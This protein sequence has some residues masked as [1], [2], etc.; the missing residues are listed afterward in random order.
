[1]FGY[2]APDTPYLFKK[3][4]KLYQAVYCGLC[5]SIGKGCGQRARTALTYDMA[6]VSALIHNIRGEDV[7]IEKKRCVLHWFK[8]RPIAKTDDLTVALGCVNTALAYNKL[9]DDKRDGD[10]KAVLRHLYKK[11]YKRAIKRFPEIK[12]II[13]EYMREQAE[14]EAAGCKIIDEA[15]EPTALMMRSVSRILLGG[16]ATAYTDKLFYSIGKWVYLI[17]ALDDYDKDVKKGRYNVI[18]NTCGQN[19]KAEAV[20]SNGGEIKF[21]FDMLFADM[22]ECLANIKFHFNHDLTDNIILRGIPLKSREI[23]AKCGNCKGACN[24]QKES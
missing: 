5:K 10:K 19:S 18:F 4:E 9:C 23:Y 11:G 16:V 21:I 13:G 22:R 20:K 12:G 6:F 14:L 3:D 1:M 24:E 17:D 7:I 2:I 8:R 15:A